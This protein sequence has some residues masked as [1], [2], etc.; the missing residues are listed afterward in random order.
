MTHSIPQNGFLIIDKPL[1]ISS[2]KAVSQVKKALQ[3]KKIGHG[4]TLD[5]LASG[6]LPLAIG[7]ATKLFD[8]IASSTKEYYFTIHFGEERSTDDAEGEVTQTTAHLPSLKDITQSLP[9]FQGIIQQTPPVFSALHMQGKRAY[10]M[11]R[12][13]DM[14]V[15]EARPVEIMQ[16]ELLDSIQTPAGITHASFSVVCGKGFYVRSLARDIARKC[17]SLGYVSSL[18]R[19]K[20]GKFAIE[21]AILLDNLV[22][23]LHSD[24]LLKAW[25]QM[26]TL[27]DDILALHLDSHQS[28][29]LR[30][31]KP[32]QISHKDGE[33]V[34]LENGKLIAMVQVKDNLLTSKRV[35]N[36]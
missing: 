19:T 20:V 3:C 36:I 10:Q 30:H 6:V 34:A 31:G 29:A 7:E 18:R 35:F 25:I 17:G 15:M 8:Y 4:G 16:L 21:G 1:G 12:A 5:P 24:S 32:L 26:E 27:L 13:G 9:Y 2:A 14:P 11:A 23:P 22:N 28:L 33:Y